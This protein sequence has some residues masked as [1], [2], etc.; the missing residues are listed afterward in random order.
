MPIASAMNAATGRRIVELG[1]AHGRPAPLSPTAPAARRAGRCRPRPGRRRRS[2]RRTRRSGAS[3]SRLTATIVD[4]V[5]IPT[6]C[7]IAPLMP[8]ARYSCGLTILPVWPICWLY[9]IQPESTAARVAPDR[10]AERR[11]QLL[12]EPEAV[13]AADAATAGDDD[14]GVV[15]R[16]GLA[17]RREPIDDRRRPAGSSSPAAVAGSDACRRVVPARR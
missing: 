9:G 10:A 11:R 2:C 1:D 15:D 5:C 6:L 12:D 17:L 3:G 7:W 4:A 16:R 8:S 13:R 14:P